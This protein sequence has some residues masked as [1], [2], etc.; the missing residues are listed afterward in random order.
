MDAVRPVR[1]TRNID[2]GEKP[3]SSDHA[4]SVSAGSEWTCDAEMNGQT[5]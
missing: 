3:F 2:V 1:L 5:T 4:V